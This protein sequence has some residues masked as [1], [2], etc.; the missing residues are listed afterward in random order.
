MDYLLAV[1]V[2]ITDVEQVKKALFDAGAGK[3]KHYDQC[4][5]QTAGQGQFRPL[6]GSNPTIGKQAHVEIIDEV[7]LELICDA[8]CLNN[9]I[10]ALRE[11]HPYEEPAFH[12]V[13]IMNNM[14]TKQ[15]SGP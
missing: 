7:K 5:W 10:H 12:V 15:K 6:P 9:V 1:Y 14:H 13:K 3:Y 2:P 11:S 8:V 4:C